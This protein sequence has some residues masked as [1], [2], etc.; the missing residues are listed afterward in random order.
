MCLSWE[1]LVRLA[2]ILALSLLL[3]L[4]VIIAFGNN[5]LMPSDHA[6]PQPMRVDY[7]G[8]G[9]P[10]NR[11]L[12]D[13]P[14]RQIVRR[15]AAPLSQAIGPQIPLPV[16]P[17]EKTVPI[18]SAVGVSPASVS[19]QRVAPMEA[20]SDKKLVSATDSISTVKIKNVGIGVGRVV[21]GVTL[22]VA[23][24]GS[25]GTGDQGMYSGHHSGGAPEVSEGNGS[26]VTI[27]NSL[28]RRSAYQDLI[29]K[30]IEAHK[31]YPLA[32]RKTRQEGSCKRRFVLTRS[33]AIKKLE[34]VSSCGHGFLDEAATHAITSV[35]VFPPLPDD[36]RG[37][38]ETFT[39]TITFTL[40]KG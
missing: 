1:G 18:K 33:G 34:V 40:D 37:G 12:D 10:R 23:D 36:F 15:R 13:Q 16:M 25:V 38:E 27:G 29:K 5:H 30:I 32:S 8:S 4:A 22:K 11:A 6:P 9:V 3:H 14:S 28:Q 26:S 21:D 17:V 31:E 39:V 19:S 35:G 2:H 24:S 7:V 20:Y